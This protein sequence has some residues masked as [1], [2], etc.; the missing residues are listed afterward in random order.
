MSIEKLYLNKSY[1]M[2]TYKTQG[3]DGLIDRL[4]KVD[5]LI[6]IDDDLECFLNHLHFFH[7]LQNHQTFY[8]YNL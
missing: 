4:R 1:V 5:L 3:F 7:L 8:Q 2:Y 6:I